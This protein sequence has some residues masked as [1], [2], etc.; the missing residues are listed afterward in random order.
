M[1]FFVYISRGF[2]LLTSVTVQSLVW[3]IQIWNVNNFCYV[4]Q[5]SASVSY[6]RLAKRALFNLWYEV[7]KAVLWICNRS[8]CTRWVGLLWLNMKRK[9]QQDAT[10]RCLLLTFVS[11]CFRHH[12]AHLQE[13]KRP[14]TAFSVLFWFC[15]MWL[16]A[17]VGRCLVG[18][19]HI[20]WWWSLPNVGEI[21]VWLY[22]EWRLYTL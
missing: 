3:K 15:R 11:T 7:F 8:L 6:C 19:E 4:H 2:C 10:I 1:D 12:Y 14:V 20:N 16:V 17:V 9:D 13:N 18:C 22:K 21:L 5:I